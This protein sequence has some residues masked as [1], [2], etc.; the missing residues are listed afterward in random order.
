MKI[1]DLLSGLG[2]LSPVAP[3]GEVPKK[4]KVVGELPDELK[5]LFAMKVKVAKDVSDEAHLATHALAEEGSDVSPDQI[6]EI[7]SHAAGAEMLNDLFWFEVREAFNLHGVD[8]VGLA[9]GW[10]VWKKDACH[11][12]VCTAKRLGSIGVIMIG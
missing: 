2:D 3:E 6:W 10:Q 11:C 9:S 4:A 1:L 12:P 8:E 7:D 5:Q